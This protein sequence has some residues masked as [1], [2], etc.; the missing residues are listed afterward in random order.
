MGA[1]AGNRCSESRLLLHIS[2]KLQQHLEEE[3]LNSYPVFMYL[4][5]NC[6]FSYL[7]FHFRHKMNLYFV[8]NEM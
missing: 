6:A 4:I 7:V 2:L 3:I 1:D 8:Q 5:S